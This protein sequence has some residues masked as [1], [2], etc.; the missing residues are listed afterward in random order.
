MKTSKMLGARQATWF[1][2]LYLLAV[3]V[4]C[5]YLVFY[6]CRAAVTTWTNDAMCYWSAW[7]GGLYDRPW[8]IDPF[9]YVYS[10]AFAQIMWPITFLAFRAFLIGWTLLLVAGLAWLI[11]PIPTAVLLFIP[12]G[13]PVIYT[14]W[15]N[16]YSGN[17]AILLAAAIVLGMRRPGCWAFVL[18]TKVT[19]GI[20]LLWFA[21]RR[22]WAALKE[23]AAVTAV[24]VAV[25][26]VIAP[27]L[28]FDWARLLADNAGSPTL[29]PEMPPL[30]VR[31]PTAAAL[32]ALGAWR[33]WKWLVPV[34]SM[35]A[36]PQVGI[37]SLIVLLAIP[38][39]LP[40][41]E[42][43]I[44]AQWPEQLTWKGIQAS[45]AEFGCRLPVAYGRLGRR[46]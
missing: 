42:P 5:G 16:V 18:L 36:L 27:Q 21:L 45:L 30:L 23:V 40:R 10:P 46:P 41:I 1:R 33:D 12:H 13:V 31:L 43:Y 6:G 29:H 20:G 38:R 25:S 8:G 2:R 28:W 15:F 26:F 22:E 11:G 35:V 37:S 14:A 7:D 19:P 9:A 3:I 32:V 39:L 4:A 34:A 17:I 44:V 24:I